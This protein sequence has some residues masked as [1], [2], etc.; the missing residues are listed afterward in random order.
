MEIS[1]CLQRDYLSSFDTHAIGGRK[2]ATKPS[3]L[4]SGLSTIF[5]ARFREQQKRR[6]CRAELHVQETIGT[7]GIFAH[8]LWDQK[9]QK[10]II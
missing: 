9:I 10:R 2:P 3:G 4:T 7:F 6:K 8:H 1:T 5:H